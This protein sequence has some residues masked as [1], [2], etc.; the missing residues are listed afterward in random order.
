[1][2]ACGIA[3]HWGRVAQSYGHRVTLLPVRYVKPYLRGHK[4]DRTDVD[5]LLDAV[6]TGHILPVSVKTVAQEE[7]VALHRLREQWMAMRTAR[8][9]ALRGFFREHGIPLPAGPRAALAAVP[10]LAEHLP[11]QLA[12]AVSSVYDDIRQKRATRMTESPAF[13][14]T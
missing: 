4:T 1:M 13:P 5:A 8:I 7:I 9:T 12:L 11:A 6:R 3:H 10:P 14:L 2:E